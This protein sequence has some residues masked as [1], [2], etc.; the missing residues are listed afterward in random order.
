[1]I[2]MSSKNLC[3]EISGD[4]L[5]QVIHTVTQNSHRYVHVVFQN[6]QIKMTGSANTSYMPFQK[7]TFTAHAFLSVK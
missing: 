1:M 5:V 2:P 3:F 4:K 7:S 6:K